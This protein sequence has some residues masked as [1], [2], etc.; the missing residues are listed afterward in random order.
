[1]TSGDKADEDERPRGLRLILNGGSSKL[2][3]RALGMSL[4][5]KATY[6][7]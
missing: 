4:S 7:V 1:M 3:G 6:R 5:P 2:V